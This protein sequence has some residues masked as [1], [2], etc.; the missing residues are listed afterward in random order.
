MPLWAT[1]S[2]A[3]PAPRRQRRRSRTGEGAWTTG[4]PAGAGGG[5]RIQRAATIAAT[6]QPAASA[7]KAPRN[8]KPAASAGSASA[9]TPPPRGI[10][11]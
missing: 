11:I 5:S 8:P 3:L 9:A 4:R 2:S 10:A 6:R 7:R 1:T